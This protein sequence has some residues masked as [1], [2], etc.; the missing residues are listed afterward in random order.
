MVWVGLVAADDEVNSDL[1]IE[2][3][4]GNTY[5]SISVG[6]EEAIGHIIKWVEAIKNSDLLPKQIVERALKDQPYLKRY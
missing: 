3:L 2:N 1:Y 6:H 5:Q 4:I